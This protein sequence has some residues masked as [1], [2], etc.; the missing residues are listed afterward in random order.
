MKYY[1]LKNSPA[2]KKREFLRKMYFEVTDIPS[3]DVNPFKTED[4]F[5]AN[6]VGILRWGTTQGER[7]NNKKRFG[8]LMSGILAAISDMILSPADAEQG[9]AK[10]E[11]GNE[12][13]VTTWLAKNITFKP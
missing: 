1:K 13:V 10:D 2:A 3:A 12:A 4:D 9:I 8:I 7:A 11:V 5:Y 6:N